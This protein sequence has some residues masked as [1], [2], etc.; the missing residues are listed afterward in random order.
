MN[1]EERTQ[2][3]SKKIKS[4]T[5]TSK[6]HNQMTKP[7]YD[8]LLKKH[9]HDTCSRLACRTIIGLVRGHR[10]GKSKAHIEAYTHTSKTGL[11]DQPK[12]V[13]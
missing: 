5:L 2:E 10:C 3:S 11:P 6:H 4:I 8:I 12:D 9:G 1:N 13:S 7:Q